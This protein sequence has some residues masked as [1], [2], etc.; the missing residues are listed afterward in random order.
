MPVVGEAYDRAVAALPHL[1]PEERA[2][3]AGRL[4][5]LQALAPQGP[6]GALSS[7]GGEDDAADE[8]L[9]LIVDA[10]LRLHGE[11]V[12]PAALR[13]APSFP[14]FR[15][16]ARELA[17]FAAE[18]AGGRVRRRAL[19]ALGVEL[20]HRDLRR[21]GM[22]V[23]SRTLMACVHQVPA[24]LDKAFPGY[25]RSGLLGMVVGEREQA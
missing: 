17:A 12:A 18:Q 23:T 25:A 19:L 8:V 16:K 10:V 7:S 14:A 20:L 11:R 1:T 21:A 4:K 3:V 6:E 22:T 13:R 5:A 2:L 9:A 15:A 24:V